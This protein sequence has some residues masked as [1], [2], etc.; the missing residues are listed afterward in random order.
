MPLIVADRVLEQSTTVGNGTM[1]LAGAALG[2]RSFASACSIGDTCW[3][4]IEGVDSFGKPTGEYEYGLGTYSAANQLARTAVRGSSNGGSLVVLTAGTKLVGIAPLS[5]GV[6]ATRDEWLSLLGALS[7]TGGT[8]TGEIIL[9]NGL[10]STELTPVGSMVLF[11]G[12]TPPSGWLTVPVA[13]TDIPRATYARLFTALG[14]TWGAGD[15]STTFGMPYVLP[16]QVF[17]QANG[18]VAAAT[19]GDVKAHTHSGGANVNLGVTSGG[20]VYGVTAANTGSVGG[21]YNLPA[22]NRSLYIIKY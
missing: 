15:G 8:M 18:N 4:Y 14:T 20:A 13:P 6:T 11:A 16:D 5:P 1:V 3:Y 7:K 17:V 9:L 2:F 10:V 12:P 19:T 22:G 21:S